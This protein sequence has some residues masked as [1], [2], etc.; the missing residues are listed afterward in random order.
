MKRTTKRCGLL[1][2]AVFTIVFSVRAVVSQNF[3]SG[4]I[5]I[6]EANYWRFYH[7]DFSKA[8]NFNI[9]G[10]WSGTT[11]QVSA[12][13]PVCWIQTPWVLV[14][15]GNISFK[16]KIDKAE[17]IPRNYSIYYIPN[18]P[19][20]PNGEG[21]PVFL[22]SAALNSSEKNVIIPIS[23][24]I[25]AELVGGIYKFKF[26][27]SGQTGS[28]KAA[29]DE[30]SAA[31]LFYSD[32]LNNGL[33]LAVTHDAD[34]DGVIDTE[35]QYPNDP[36]RAY[37]N[38]Y[39]SQNVFGTLVFEDNWPLKGDYDLNDV[40][41]D[42]NINKV[43][44]SLNE[45][46]EVK[47]KF[48]MRAAGANYHNGFAF[49]LDG[50]TNNKIS[51]VSGCRKSSNSY[52]SFLSNGLESGQAYANCIVFDDFFNE[53]QRPDFGIGIN[54]EPTAPFI[55]VDS[56]FVTLTLL[57]NGVPPTGGKLTLSELSSD[58]FN[59]YIISNRQRGV[60]VHLVDR[61][62]T[63]LADPTLFNTADDV[64]I[65]PHYYRTANNLPWGLNLIQPFDYPI[66][67]VAINEAYLHF[68][69]WAESSGSAF[70]DWYTNK[71]GYRN[72]SKIYSKQ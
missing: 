33:P 41:V 40:V 39:P 16:M 45:V 63:A 53:M 7:I 56:V 22:D 20:R 25:P 29:V 44:N 1:L 47:S 17:S 67:K 69:Q 66:E 30:F 19:S 72:T 4:S 42:Y 13:N 59:F 24:T 71:P 35:D 61:V 37:N 6:E 51:S 68:V 65:A 28:A 11:T 31:G 46:V 18:D 3:E 62:P 36:Y 48:A 26:N 21:V 2:A 60:E 49:Q 8:T 5:P 50:I 14:E 23:K 27:F 54:T 12:S 57:Q 70:Q 10:D 32:L 64:S 43:T 58:L 34:G 15:A 52:I 38:Y 9:S 55:E